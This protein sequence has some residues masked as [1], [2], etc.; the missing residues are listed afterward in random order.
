MV[1]GG[2]GTGCSTS[3]CLFWVARSVGSTIL[4]NVVLI[5]ISLLAPGRTSDLASSL[6]PAVRCR[7]RASKTRDFIAAALFSDLKANLTRSEELREYGV[8]DR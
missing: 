6:I 7:T 3:G 1:F 8:Q 5:Q 2:G 4:I